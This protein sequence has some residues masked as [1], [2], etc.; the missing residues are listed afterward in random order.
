M[1]RRLCVLTGFLHHLSWD[2][3]SDIL[4]CRACNQE[5]WSSSPGPLPP[6]Q[7]C[8]SESQ[9][10][11]EPVGKFRLLG[12]PE[13]K[14]AGCGVGGWEMDS[15][16]KH[17]IGLK[18]LYPVSRWQKT[19]VPLAKEVVWALAMALLV[20][21]ARGKH[22]FS[23]MDGLS[24]HLE[25]FVFTKSHWLLKLKKKINKKPLRL[26]TF[27]RFLKQTQPQTGQQS[28]LEGQ[29]KETPAG[30]LAHLRGLYLL[31]G[32]RQFPPLL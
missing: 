15:E 7:P 29:S 3:C 23:K 16:V 32:L 2:P 21:T 28:L 19:W 4:C 9:Q 10:S 5:P 17:K 22:P 6:L 13:G 18:G 31:P 30:T 20:H 27:E 14:P 11:S 1:P 8:P 26:W 24:P 25:E 12:E